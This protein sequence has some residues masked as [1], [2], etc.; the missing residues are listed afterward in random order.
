MS[1]ATA[2]PPLERLKSALA[3]V[4]DL[5]HAESILDWDS[6][7]SMPHAGALARAHATANCSLPAPVLD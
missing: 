4:A 1:V 2:S 7:V 3:Q 6:R 5:K